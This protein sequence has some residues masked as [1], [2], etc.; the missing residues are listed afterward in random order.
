MSKFH[1]HSSEDRGEK[2]FQTWNCLLLFVIALLV[3][4]EQLLNYSLISEH[5]ELAEIKYNNK[6][7]IF[8]CIPPNS[9]VD[10]VVR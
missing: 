1:E 10:T 7:I 2:T 6:R 5:A 4:K 3:A 9:T 8:G